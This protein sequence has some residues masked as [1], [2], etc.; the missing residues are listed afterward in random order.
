[1]KMFDA[2]VGGETLSCYLIDVVNPHIGPVAEDTPLTA[3]LI[4]HVCESFGA[5][6]LL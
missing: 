1:M 6:K 2:V 5:E 4:M 3:F